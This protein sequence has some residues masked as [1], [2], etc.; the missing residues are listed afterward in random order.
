MNSSDQQFDNWYKH[1]FGEDYLLVYQHRDQQGATAEVEAMAG[2]LQLPRGAKVFDLCCG[3]GRHSLALQGLGFQVTGMD[4]SEALLREARKKDKQQKIQWLQGDMREVPLPSGNFDAVV[5]LFTSFGYFNEDDQNRKV[6][7]EMERVLKPGGKFIID[8]LNPDFVT[9]HL[10]PRSSRTEG[11]LQIEETRKVE[12]QTVQ[13]KIVIQQ[14]GAAPETARTYYERVKLY[15]L[16]D[17]QSML[18]GVPLQIDHVFGDYD[19]SGYR[20][21]TSPRMIM[22]GTKQKGDEL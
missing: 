8:F 18:Q 17:F 16:D 10:V 2:W 9:A 3:M 15:H 22:V 1:S 14:I 5:N 12:Q 6:L 4:L 19:Q 20:P 13:K 11:H 21:E 7:Q